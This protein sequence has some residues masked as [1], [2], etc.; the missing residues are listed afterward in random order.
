M[1][2]V[3]M[4]PEFPNLGMWKKDQEFKVTFGYIVNLRLAW[5]I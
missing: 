4:Y 3:I 1:K 2:D 5:T